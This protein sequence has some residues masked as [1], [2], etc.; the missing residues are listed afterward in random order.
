MALVRYV[1]KASRHCAS[2]KIQRAALSSITN[3]SSRGCSLLLTGT[4][5][6]PAHQQANS[7]STY[8]GWLRDATTTRSPVA[9][10]ASRSAAAMRATRAASDA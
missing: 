6:S 5:T 8:A 3:A 10:P 7:A 2:V 1:A 9:S 4:A